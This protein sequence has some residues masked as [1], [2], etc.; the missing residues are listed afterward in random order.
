MR[1]SFLGSALVAVALAVACS[2]AAKP[3]TLCT[4]NLEVFCR[5]QDR[6]EGQKQCSADGKSYGPCVPCE[7]FDNPEGPLDPGDPT[8]PELPEFDAGEEKPEDAGVTPGCGNGIVDKDEDC[9]DRTADGADGCDGACKLA[10]GTSLA[11]SGCPGL[12]VHV[13]G[14]L[15]KPTLSATTVGSGNRNIKPSCAAA[16]S[17]TTSGTTAADRVFKVTAHAT[18]TMTVALT[19]VAYNAFLYVAKTCAA[20]DVATTACVNKVDG[21]G[22][23]TLTFP[24]V[25]GSWTGN[26]VHALQVVTHESGPYAGLEI[27]YSSAGES[28]FQIHDVTDKANIQLLATLVYPGHGYT[29]QGWLD[30]DNQLFYLNDEGDEKQGLVP[31]TTTYVFDVSDIYAPVLAATFTNGSHAIDHNLM[32][33]DGFVF[34]ANY[35][36]GLRIYDARLDPLAPVEVG[37]VDTYPV[38]DATSFNGAWG[39]YA[40]LPS[41]NILVGDIN[42]GLFVV[43]PHDALT[44]PP[45]AVVLAAPADGAVLR[46]DLG[47]LS[48]DAA[49]A[50]ASV[51]LT[52]SADPTL[53]NPAV[54]LELDPAETSALLADLGLASCATWYWGVT[55]HNAN[56]DTA[57]EVR[58]FTLS[59]ASDIVTDGVVNAAD[60]RRFKKAAAAAHPMADL[61][62]N[63][64]IDAADRGILLAEMGTVCP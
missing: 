25:T 63:G 38:N 54:S 47:G 53:A 11:T 32:F 44:L 45:E 20:V 19:G 24:V 41:G 23:E 37:W 48:W 27:S 8:F 57:S 21:N 5:C 12:D 7:T 60:S 64:V 26:Y 50:A 33:K 59:V 29:H 52:V 43:D 4:A 28:G 46:P 58:S 62:G 22:A 10:G 1:L 2:T 3:K 17:T 30:W 18:G 49:C 34:E 16:G 13:W 56:G 15:H 36:S 55:A 42:G 61:D 39:V 9:D 31:S 6:Q 14:G 35:T 51:T 40:D